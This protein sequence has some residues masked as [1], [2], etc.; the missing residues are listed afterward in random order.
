MSATEAARP[1]SYLS[2][3]RLIVAEQFGCSIMVPARTGLVESLGADEVDL[4]EIVWA[5]ER[6]TGQRVP[7][8]EAETIRTVGD[9]IACVRRLTPTAFTQEG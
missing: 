7:D 1:T 6:V 4:L 5:V 2:A 8:H 9:V 3:A